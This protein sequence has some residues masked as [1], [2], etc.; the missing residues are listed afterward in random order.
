VAAN[1]NVDLVSGQILTAS[2][3]NRWPRGVVAYNNNLTTDST[4]TVEEQ[5]VAP[6]TFT[7]VANRLYKLTYFEPGFGGTAASAMIM[8]IRK[9]NITGAIMNECSV[10]NST[11][12]QQSGI[13]VAYD[14]LT[15]GSNTFLCTLQCS[16][17]TGS[18][19]RSATKYANFCV[20]DL[21]PY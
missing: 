12:Q 17:G 18:A 7:A 11:V 2:I 9:T 20:E 15:A 1:P 3:S 10:Y 6:V 16:A 4:V 13:L 21:G 8:R 14:T 5:E 19:T